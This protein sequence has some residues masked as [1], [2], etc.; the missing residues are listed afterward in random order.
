MA[1]SKIAGFIRLHVICLVLA[2]V[3]IKVAMPEQPP[4]Q[5]W[6]Q[7]HL[8]VG[9]PMGMPMAAQLHQKHLRVGVPTGMP[10]VARVMERPLVAQGA[11]RSANAVRV[12]QLRGKPMAAQLMDMSGRWPGGWLEHD[13]ILIGSGLMPV[14]WYKQTPTHRKG[15]ELRLSY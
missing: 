4:C 7:K 3:G 14:P 12:H 13:P 5:M 15:L 2:S 11:P 1:V 6:N 9:V 8:P 10:M